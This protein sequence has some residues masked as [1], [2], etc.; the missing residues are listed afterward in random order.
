MWS[1]AGVSA[2]ALVAA[3]L[4]LQV[5]AASSESGGPASSTLADVGVLGA[6]DRPAVPESSASSQVTQ[7]NSLLSSLAFSASV[8]SGSPVTDN[9]P[10]A[11]QRDGLSS[12]QS[13][14]GSFKPTP[15]PTDSTTP[16]PSPTGTPTPS[17]TP[18]PTGTPTPSDTST[19]TGTPTPTDT[20]TPADISTP[21]DTPSPLVSPSEA[22]SASPT[23]TASES[24]PSSIPSPTD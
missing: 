19:P 1:V 2:A 11:G 14:G 8:R 6:L 12:G 3:C 20:L 24:S 10:S 17:G 4:N 15:L 5:I 13:N 9:L 18:S 23:P 22:E 7:E 21:T 16:T